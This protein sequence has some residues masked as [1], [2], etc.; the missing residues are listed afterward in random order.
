MVQD[1][2]FCFQ[3]YLRLFEPFQYFHSLSFHS[4]F[5]ILV[6]QILMLRLI[7]IDN[8]LRYSNNVI[9]CLV[10]RIHDIS[11][12][13]YS[14]YE[15]LR[16]LCDKKKI[17]ERKGEKE[18]C[19][20]ILQ[21][22]PLHSLPSRTIAQSQEV[23]LRMIRKVPKE[24]LVVPSY[25]YPQQQYVTHIFFTHLPYIAHVCHKIREKR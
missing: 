16:G 5:T 7:S 10:I 17:K 6:N 1:K 3:V 11:C 22:F 21:I 4:S 2:R 14:T 25:V 15:K 18:K 19:Q 24:S 13:V 9:Y 12:Y 8:P 20:R 23:R